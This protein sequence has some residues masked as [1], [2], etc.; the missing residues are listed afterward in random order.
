MRRA[1]IARQRVVVFKPMI[2]DRSPDKV[3]LAGKDAVFPPRDVAPGKSHEFVLSYQG[4]NTGSDVVQLVL[5]SESLGKESLTKNQ[6]I[7]VGK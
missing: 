2:D 1:Q 7:T 3:Q 6:T 5:T 4:V